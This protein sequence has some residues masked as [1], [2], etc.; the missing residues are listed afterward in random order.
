MEATKAAKQPNLN[1]AEIHLF[2]T[3]LREAA[4]ALNCPF[5]NDTN[6]DYDEKNTL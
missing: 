5:V 6:P 2:I 3:E 4:R 1:P